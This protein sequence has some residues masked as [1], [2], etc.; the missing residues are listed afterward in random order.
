MGASFAGE[1]A[2]PSP[3]SLIWM[4]LAG[5][6]AVSVVLRAVFVGEQSL[7]YEEVYTASVVSHPTVSGVWNAVRATESTPPLYYLLTWLWVKL[8]ASH[9]AVAL[10]T[11]SLL[12]GSV[13]VPVS[14]FAA[15]SFVGRRLALAVAW[16]CAISPVLVGYSIYARS[17]ALMVLL[18]TLSV[19]ALGALL[20]RPSGLRWALWGA[21]AAACLWTHYFTVF[22]VIAE[23]AVLLVKL[24][25]GRRELLLCLIAV[26]VATAPLWSLFLSQNGES[27]RTGFIA[28]RPL[29][30]R[31]E[32]TV[33]QFAMGTN[34]P[35]A[36]LEG[37]GILLVGAATVFAAART[38]RLQA[39]QV[40]GA[41]ALI[42]AGLPILSALSG[43]DDHLLARNILG[44]WICLAP[45]AA[46][47]LTRLRGVPLLAYSV[48]C[49]VTVLAVQSNWRYQ[50]ASD[51]RG[52]SA[53]IRARASGE[54]V[55]VM[56]ALQSGV[57]ALY[58]HRAPLALP[59]LTQNLWVM[60][61]P[62]RGAGERA[63]NPVPDPPLT[64]LWGPRFS[65]V[66]EIDYRGFRLIHLRA[67]SPIAVARAPSSDGPATAPLA[68]VLGP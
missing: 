12:A 30:G 1:L 61:E 27:A 13:T 7:G 21:A 53:R 32:D 68:L 31:L 65:A 54:P 3:S 2:R 55:A 56:P 44:V 59:V 8:T 52:A 60:V 34:V 9:A 48:I 50:A 37:A 39:A 49:I 40:L 64:Q 11:T 57:A 16:L 23:A 5:A 36:W 24:R 62:V 26:A 38:Y 20:A 25:D 67:P 41:L 6:C 33:R 58:L 22:L 47:G 17:Y 18:A 14:F 51:W 43:V 46:Y 63:L 66:A 35:A 45:F 15:R 28:A 19:W 10:R 4:G 29:G 42:G